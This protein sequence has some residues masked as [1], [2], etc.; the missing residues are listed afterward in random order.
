MTINLD[1]LLA[2]I[3]HELE[4]GV[5]ERCP[6]YRVR[7]ATT[8][9][10]LLRAEQAWIRDRTPVNP[11]FKS[12]CKAAGAFLLENSAATDTTSSKV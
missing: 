4:S 9:E 7:L 11:A 6:G 5:E 2:T 10:R 12:E 3:E 8:I 1:R